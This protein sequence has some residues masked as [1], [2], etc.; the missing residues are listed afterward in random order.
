[1]SIKKTVGLLVGIGAGLGLAWALR[2]KF[3]GVLGGKDLEIVLKTVVPGEKAGVRIQPA[4]VMVFKDTDITWHVTNDSDKD[5]VVSLANWNDG[6]GHGRRPAVDADV[7][8]HDHE[9]PP[10]HDLSRLVPAGK[11]RKIRGKSRKADAVIETVYYDVNL[12]GTKGVDPI[13]RLVL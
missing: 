2:H 4:D 9:H 7:D 1:M 3:A 8:P 10:Q 6:E 13:V 11:K 12:D 5:V